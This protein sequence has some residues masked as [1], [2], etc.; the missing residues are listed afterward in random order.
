[1]ERRRPKMHRKQLLRLLFL[2]FLLHIVLIS[3]SFAADVTREFSVT[4]SISI[5]EEYNDNIFL[6]SSDE[7]S[8]F[9]T[10]INPAINFAY[11]TRIITLSL[12]YG[13]DFKFYAHNSDQNET[14]LSETQRLNLDTTL[15]LYKDIFFVKISDV[16]QRVPI[17][18]RRQV[19]FDNVFVNLTDTNTFIIN[20]YIEYPLAKTVRAN[21]GYRYTN[22]WYRDDEGND[23]ENH[24]VY[25]DVAK[26][27]TPN[28]NATVS[29]DY[30]DHQT[31]GDGIEDQDRKRH[32]ANVGANYQISPRLN[33]GGSIGH[34]WVDYEDSD[35]DNSPEWDARANYLLTELISLSA[36]YSQSYGDSVNEGPFVTER[37]GGTFSYNGK[38]PVNITVHNTESDYELMDRIDKSTGVIIDSTIPIPITPKLS[39]TLS[40]S[41][42][43]FEFLP[44]D[45]EVDRYSVRLSF[46]YQ[47]RITTINLGYTFNYSDSNINGNDY[48]NNI[49]WIQARF[50]L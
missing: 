28:L 6:T 42:S 31:D 24:S 7:E 11:R 34:T 1:M 3:R 12:D 27:F 17:D 18:E 36:F 2:F 50:T 33:L 41:Y 44:E 20:P 45:E 21:T 47:L 37:I 26:E 38:V 22:I 10:T 43:S 48:K 29:Y 19:A 32:S 16:Y 46:N 40:G 4:P 5:R 15:S 30:S 14:S 39:G 49:V 25:L 23:S 9:I 35:N 8:D 13:L